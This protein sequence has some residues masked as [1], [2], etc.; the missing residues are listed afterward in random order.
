M[1]KVNPL[2]FQLLPTTLP[3]LN[4]HPL[5]VVSGYHDLK[6]QVAEKKNL[7]FKFETK[8]LKILMFKHTF[9]PQ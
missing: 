9:Y 5:D 2:M 6:L 3:N 7:F 4:F 8:Y 1:D